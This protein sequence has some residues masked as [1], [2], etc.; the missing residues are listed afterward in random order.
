MWSISSHA[1]LGGRM[2]SHPR[3]ESWCSQ[4]G[5]HC[6]TTRLVAKGARW[7]SGASAGLSFLIA[8]WLAPSA[9]APLDYS[10]D[11]TWLRSLA[12]GWFLSRM[13]GWRGF[14]NKSSRCPRD[15]LG[16]QATANFV[17]HIAGRMEDNCCT[18]RRPDPFTIKKLEPGN[19]NSGCYNGP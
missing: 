18:K 14:S 7:P 15:V 4:T 12:L 6:K 3:R 9:P 8:R 19:S 2:V 11:T 1:L 5:C 16:S 10:V 13:R 17:H